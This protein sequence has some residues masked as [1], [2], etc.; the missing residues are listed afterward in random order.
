M[1][2]AKIGIELYLIYIGL[3]V[4]GFAVCFY[5]NF[6]DRKAQLAEYLNGDEEQFYGFDS[7]ESRDKFNDNI[8]KT[9]EEIHEINISV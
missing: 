3:L 1:N 9:V 8:R 2:I 7:N 5:L 6:Y 4:I